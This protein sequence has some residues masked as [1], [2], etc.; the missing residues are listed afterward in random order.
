MNLFSKLFSHKTQQNEKKAVGQIVTFPNTGKQAPIAID[1]YQ[2]CEMVSKNEDCA[3][4]FRIAEYKNQV[5]IMMQHFGKNKNPTSFPL[6]CTRCSTR[7]EKNLAF[8]QSITGINSNTNLYKGINGTQEEVAENT[9]RCPHCRLSDKVIMVHSIDKY[10][11]DIPKPEV[12]QSDL[13]LIRMYFK[14]L[15]S[16]WWPGNK[17]GAKMCDSCMTSIENGDGYMYGIFDKNVLRADRLYCEECINKILSDP[18][19]LKGLQ[20]D[21]DYMGKGLVQQARE[22][23][24]HNKS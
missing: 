19:L 17:T 1:I 6:I 8:S 22:Y 18:S 16:L 24:V 11:C 2:F 13:Q 12:T 21:P 20:R 5:S 3:L 9:G 4:I 23:F 10:F 15:A 7:L 14:Y